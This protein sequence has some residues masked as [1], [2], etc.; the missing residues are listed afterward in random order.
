MTVSAVTAQ[1]RALRSS[2]GLM[3]FDHVAVV[4]IEGPDAFA[5]V[6]ALSPSPLFL[7]EGQMRHTLLLDGDARPAADLYVCSDEEEFILLADGLSTANLVARLEA[8]RAERLPAGEVR[9][10]A[11]E[12]SHVLFGVHGPYAWEVAGA[13]IGPT[14]LG[15]PYLSLM[16]VDEIVCLR[17]GKTGEFGYDFL[18]TRD[19]ADEI[20]RCLLELGAAFDLTPVTLPALDLCALENWHFNIRTLRET[21]L[22]QPLT[23]IELQL[24]WRV[25][26]ARDFVGA[27]ALRAR[28][29]AG[30]AVRATFFTSRAAVAPGQPLSFEREPCGEVL[31]AA[32]SPTL[33]GWVGAALVTMRLAH[34]GLELTVASESGAIAVRTATPP[35]VRNRSLFVDPHRHTYRTRDADVFPPLVLT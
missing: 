32:A 26:Y 4:R 29:A 13:F 24:Q 20:E 9:V 10:Q 21:P 11:L 19:S 22:A 12:E 35:L 30:P 7:R 15:M 31:A 33:G 23:P 6:D 25:G 1:V 27:D 8:R 16:R 5:L 18:V 14:V 28:R 17:S 2:A 34:P 3:R